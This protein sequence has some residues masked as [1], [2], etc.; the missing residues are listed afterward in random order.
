M[1]VECKKVSAPF[2]NQNGADAFCKKKRCV[3]KRVMS[4]KKLFYHHFPNVSVI[5]FHEIHTVACRLAVEPHAVERKPNVI[6]N[7]RL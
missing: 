5:V 4:R 1:G 7:C 2:R 6:I 3:G